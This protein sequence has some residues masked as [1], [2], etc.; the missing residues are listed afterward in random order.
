MTMDKSQIEALFVCPNC[1]YG[2]T[3]LAIY[4]AHFEQCPKCRKAALELF[5]EIEDGRENKKAE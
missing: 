4:H 5:E 1:G 3:G 2:M